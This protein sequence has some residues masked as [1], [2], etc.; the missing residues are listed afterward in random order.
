MH[1]RAAPTGLSGFLFLIGHEV[2]QEN[3]EVSWSG[4]M[5][6]GCGHISLYTHRKDSEN[7]T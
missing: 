6:G 5:A 3:S 2:G 7:F 1:R 4:D